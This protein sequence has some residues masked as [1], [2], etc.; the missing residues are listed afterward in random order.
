[1]KRKLYNTLI[2]TFA[3]AAAFAVSTARAAADRSDCDQAL[4]N[5]KSADPTLQ[6]VI[7][8]SA[9]YVVFPNVGKGG[10][11]VGGAHGKGCV[12]EKGQLI[13]RATMTQGS[14][15]AQIGGQSFSELIVFQSSTALDNFK[16][17]KFE[18]SA[19]VSAV[20][21]KTGA[22][23]AAKYTEG[24]AV[25]TMAKKGLM[26]EAAVGGQ[27]FKFEPMTTR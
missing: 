8:S 1:M 25:F 3:V 6:G 7:D 11:I 23:Q 26:A 22:S 18:M 13:G 21:V 16:S 24:V 5:F 27:K 4:S 17:G 20:A 9:G 12:F 19:G 2:V 10:F 14:V 15:G